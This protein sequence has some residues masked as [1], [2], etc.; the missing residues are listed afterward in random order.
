[1]PKWALK[2]AKIPP[3]RGNHENISKIFYDKIFNDSQ[4]IEK[5]KPSPK[6]AATRAG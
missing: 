5:H 3:S 4:E 2:Y 1:M 6:M